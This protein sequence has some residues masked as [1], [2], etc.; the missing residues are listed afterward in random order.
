MHAKTKGRRTDRLWFEINIPYFSN[1]K[2]GI[3]I[4]IIIIILIIIILIDNLKRI[5]HKI[6]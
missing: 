4:I 6:R 2:A 5:T 1:E 3:I